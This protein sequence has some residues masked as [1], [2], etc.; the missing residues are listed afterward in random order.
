MLKVF[1]A[2]LEEAAVHYQIHKNQNW[3]EELEKN[4]IAIT[5]VFKE[6]QEEIESLKEEI[7][8]YQA[9]EYD[10]WIENRERESRMDAYND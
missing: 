1:L 7:K 5:K 2:R 9:N 3:S 10:N 4:R 6:K 8:Q